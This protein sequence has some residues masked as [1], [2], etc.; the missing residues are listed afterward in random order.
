[1]NIYYLAGIICF[2]FLAIKGIEYKYNKDENKSFK[3]AIIDTIYIFTAVI[4]GDIVIKQIN[5]ILKDTDPHVF[6]DNPSF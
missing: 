1:M 3:L 6:I 4:L 5:P 2:I